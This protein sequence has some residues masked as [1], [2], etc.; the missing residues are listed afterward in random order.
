MI[1]GST[2]ARTGRTAGLWRTLLD[3]AAYGLAVGAVSALG[4][5]LLRALLGTAEARPEWQRM[6][7]TGAI[8]LLSVAIVHAFMIWRGRTTNIR[9]GWLR[10][11]ENV[12]GL[13]AG[14]LAGLAM[15]AGCYGMLLASGIGRLVPAPGGPIDYL[16][17]LIPVVVSFGLL[18]AAE[19][20]LFR[21]YPLTKLALLTGPTWANVILSVLFAMAHL[22]S[23]GTTPLVMANVF[24]G[25]LTVGFLRFSRF[26]IPAAIGFHAAWNLAQLLLGGTISGMTSPMPAM[27]L[28]TEG[29]SL[30]TGAGF[31]PEGSLWA[32]LATLAMLGLIKH[33]AEW[34]GLRGCLPTPAALRGRAGK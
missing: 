28:V 18:A 21:G 14:A 27:R 33:R 26:G 12:R 4:G 15:I 3:L 13:T 5:V 8:I 30:L 25:S 16:R 19:E 7:A 11:L 6:L 34:L 20:V 1:G 2:A 24:L 10:G 32:T 17:M 29:P 31:G 9:S 23:A 22:G